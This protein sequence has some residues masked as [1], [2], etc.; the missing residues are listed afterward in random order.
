LFKNRR[1]NQCTRRLA[2]CTLHYEPFLSG[3]LHEHGPVAG[4][5]FWR[6]ILH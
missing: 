4:V 6:C 2:H 3:P 5:H 1:F